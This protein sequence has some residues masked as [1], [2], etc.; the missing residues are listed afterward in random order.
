[1]RHL[2]C[3][4]VFGLAWLAASPAPAA[5]LPRRLE[6]LPPPPLA[7]TGPAFD[8]TGVYGGL[9]AGYGFGIPDVVSIRS[10]AVTGR[11]SIPGIFK[12]RGFTGGIQAGY[13]YQ[14][15]SFVFGLEG[16]LDLGGLRDSIVNTVIAAASQDRL[17]GTLRS[18]IGVV[19]MERLLVYATAGYAFV[20]NRY[21]VSGRVATPAI[22]NT[23]IYNGYAAGGGLEYAFTDHLSVKLES[24]Y[25][26]VG[27]KVLAN[28]NR[29]A[30]TSATPSLVSVRAG[31]N[32]RY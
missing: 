20:Q 3:A 1:M 11:L 26:S 14:F 10:P 19:S 5:D 9:N 28:A 8:W 32:Y 29:T 16:D 13:N 21:N 25:H 24:I 2:N 4:S 6:P 30:S 7:A 31:V 18:R 12:P 22:S 27:K 17:F 23:S 15:G